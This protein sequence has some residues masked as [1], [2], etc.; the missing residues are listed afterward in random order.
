MILSTE[1][2]STAVDSEEFSSF[3]HHFLLSVNILETPVTELLQ[4]VDIFTAST[5]N[6]HL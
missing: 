6:E 5:A 2:L 1:I 4:Y 3:G